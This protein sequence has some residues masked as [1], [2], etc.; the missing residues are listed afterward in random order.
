MKT[1]GAAAIENEVRGVAVAV[2]LVPRRAVHGLCLT[3]LPVAAYVHE[4]AELV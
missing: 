4:K 1:N 3:P 2:V